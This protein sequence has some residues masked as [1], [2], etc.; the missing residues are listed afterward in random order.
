M[1][2]WHYISAIVTAAVI[3]MISEVL[4]QPWGVFHGTVVLFLILI[5]FWLAAIFHKI[6]ALVPDPNQSGKN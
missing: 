5:S 4:G 2:N 3:G 6:K 1:N